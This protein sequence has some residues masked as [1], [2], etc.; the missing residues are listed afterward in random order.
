MTTS[1]PSIFLRRALLAD[2]AV[3]GAAGALMLLGAGPLTGLLGIP[4][5]L[6]RVAGLALLPYAALVLRLGRSE[7]PARAAV[8]AV[9]AVNLLW[10][11]GCVL[12]LLAGWIAPT[13]L[14]IAFVVAQATAVALFAE[15]QVLGLRRTR[16]V[17]TA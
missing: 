12:L 3:S 1:Q 5:L 14:G 9:I 8:W 2:A 10:A 13:G 15:L 11:A 4:A 16:V 7:R 6:L 17:A